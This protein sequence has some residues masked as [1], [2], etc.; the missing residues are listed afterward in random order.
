MSALE[1]LRTWFEANKTSKEVAT[2]CEI[3]G[4]IPQEKV[5]EIKAMY[6]D[7]QASEEERELAFIFTVA[8]VTKSSNLA[9]VVLL[10]MAGDGDKHHGTGLM[11]PVSHVDP[12]PETQ[13]EL[14]PLPPPVPAEH[15]PE[16]TK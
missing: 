6:P 1:G 10:A 4:Q 7:E 3:R 11:V 9:A 12:A 16:P 15:D 2:A 13:P 8:T 14:A 5:D